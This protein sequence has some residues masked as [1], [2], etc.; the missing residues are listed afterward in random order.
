[1]IRGWFGNKIN[2]PDFSIDQ[3][4]IGQTDLVRLRGGRSGAQFWSAFVPW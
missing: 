1:M 4:P 2:A 3:L